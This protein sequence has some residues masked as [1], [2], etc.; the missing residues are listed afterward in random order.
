MRSFL[1][2][3]L[4][5]GRGCGALAWQDYSKETFSISTIV[6]QSRDLS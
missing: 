6:S 2:D 5:D 1:H 3:Y 4:A